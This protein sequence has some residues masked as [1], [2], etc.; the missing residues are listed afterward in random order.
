MHDCDAILQRF[1]D[2]LDGQLPETALTRLRHEAAALPDCLATLDAMLSVHQ[3][4][5]SAPMA[6]SARDFSLSVTQELAWRQ[7]RDKLFLGGVLFLVALTMLAPLLLVLWAGLAAVLEPGL[8][9]TAISSAISFISAA[10]TYGAAIIAVLQHM[11]QWAMIAFSTF[12]SL[13]FLLLAL[14]L[15]MK[16][17]PEQLF[18]PSSIARQAI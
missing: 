17:A 11:P 8:I 14:A 10:A 18:S 9:Q 6:E 7:R 16:K 12:F 3:A 1:S 2:Y 5:K 13:S 4:L 15:A